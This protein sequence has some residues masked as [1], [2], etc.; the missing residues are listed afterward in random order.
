MGCAC[1]WRQHHRAQ[2]SEFGGKQYRRAKFFDVCGRT[3]ARVYAAA[4]SGDSTLAEYFRR[5]FM[6]K[7]RLAETIDRGQKRIRR[8]KIFC[9]I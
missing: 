8:L 2:E 4:A 9:C 1:N 7:S 6:S 5:V 3:A